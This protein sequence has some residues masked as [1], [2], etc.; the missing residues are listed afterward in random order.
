MKKSQNTLNVII[1][2]NISEYPFNITDITKISVLQQPLKT[3]NINFSVTK[4]NLKVILIICQK[5]PHVDL[6][7]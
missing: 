5:H 6:N 4:E 3:K 2:S 1:F 7:V